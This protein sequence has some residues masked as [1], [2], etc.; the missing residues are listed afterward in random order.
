MNRHRRKAH[1]LPDLAL[2][3]KVAD[4]ERG[5]LHQPLKVREVCHGGQVSE[6]SLQIRRDIAVTHDGLTVPVG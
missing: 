5:S 1:I 6:V 4:T 2:V 3:Q